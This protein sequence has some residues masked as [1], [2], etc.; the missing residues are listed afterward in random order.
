M[1]GSADV[2]IEGLTVP[3]FCVAKPS[4]GTRCSPARRAQATRYRSPG[5]SPGLGIAPVASF[6]RGP[7]GGSPGGFTEVRPP[8]RSGWCASATY[9]ARRRSPA[10]S[11]TAAA[12]RSTATTSSRSSR[13]T[14]PTSAAAC[15][16]WATTPTRALRRRPGRRTA[17]V[18]HVDPDAPGDTSSAISPIAATLPDEAFDCIVLTQTLHLVYDFEAALRNVR[19]AL[20][21][22]RRAAPHGARDQQRRRRRVGRTLALLVHSPQRGPCA[23]RCFDGFDVDTT[24][25]GN[26]LAAVAFLHG[27]GQDELTRAELDDLHV[28]YALVHG[29]RAVKPGA[30]GR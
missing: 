25:Y 27:L 28:E 9:A 16:R 17:D 22:G 18:L 21:A 10:T 13:P 3:T 11:A 15:S 4:R 24:S 14:P 6:R 7:V 5:C 23:P 8:L 30:G 12:D 26:V 1:A 29:V 2:T 19:Q 20:V